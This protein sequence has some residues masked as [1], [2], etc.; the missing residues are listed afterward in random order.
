MMR[1]LGV[2]AAAIVLSAPAAVAARP[3]AVGVGERE[4][5]I[6]L[7]RPWV[8]AGLVKFNVKNFGEDGHDFVVRNALGVTR[9]RLP[10]LGAGEAASVTGRLIRR[11]RYTVY[12][13]LPGHR[14]LGMEAVLR[15][16][17]ASQ[18]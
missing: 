16:G 11:G 1:S 17:R 9:A 18:R 12:C 2:L 8:P 6:A 5:R 3:T 10:E 7:Y 4:W 14:E 13:S 15:V